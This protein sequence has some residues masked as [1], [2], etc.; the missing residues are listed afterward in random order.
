MR[1]LTI[2]GIIGVLLLAGCGWNRLPPEEML[3][4]AVAQNRTLGSARFEAEGLL[5]GTLAG[6]TR[7]M[8]FL[9]TD[10][11]VHE[12][13]KQVK[14]DVQ[15]WQEGE[16]DAERFRAEAVILQESEAYVRV[17]SEGSVAPFLPFSLSSLRLSSGAWL[18]LPLRPDHVS[19]GAITPDPRLLREQG[20]VIRVLSDAG[21]EEVD[22]RKTRHLF[23]AVDTEKLSKFLSRVTAEERRSME[24]DLLASFLMASQAHGEIWIDRQSLHIRRLSWVIK[25]QDKDAEISFLLT[26]RD[27]DAAP[28]IEPPRA[29]EVIRTEPSGAQEESG[30]AERGD[31]LRSSSVSVP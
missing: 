20:D 19:T 7:T 15:V 31:S 26:L 28:A 30:E 1:R 2:H 18:R 16:N 9:V 24:G 22:G 21:E 12:G 10:G 8:R 5:R 17:A 27:H 25:E 4:R 3:Q 29:D 13:G 6:S 23:I 11:L 14:G